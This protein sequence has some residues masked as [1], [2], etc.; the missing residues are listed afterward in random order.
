M[1]MIFSPF[2]PQHLSN[3]TSP[4]HFSTTS[5]PDSGSPT[6]AQSLDPIEE[7][8]NLGLKFTLPPSLADPEMVLP[9]FI[10]IF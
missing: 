8:S 2:S 6:D 4:N 1:V 10:F 7:F 9:F 5:T 3:S